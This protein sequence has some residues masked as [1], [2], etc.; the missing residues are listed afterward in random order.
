[1][2]TSIKTTL[3]AVALGMASVAN[4]SMI[5]QWSYLNEAGFMDPS[6]GTVNTT[7]FQSAGSTILSEDTY[8][9]LNWGT[10]VVPAEG[11]SSLEIDTPISGSITTVEVGDSLEDSDFED[12][13]DI[14]HNNYRISGASLETATILD[15]LQ[16]VATAWDAAAPIGLIGGLAPEL[17]IG[18]EFLET[19]NQ[20]QNGI[21]VDGSVAGTDPNL[22]DFGCDDFFIIYP[23]PGVTITVNDLGDADP[24]N[25]YV[26]FK[27]TFDLIDLGFPAALAASLDLITKYEVVTRLTGL[28]INTLFCGTQSIP[29]IGFRT[30][31]LAT[32]VLQA[33]FA[34]RAVPAPASLAFLGMGIVA[35]ALNARRKRVQK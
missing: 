29:C 33:S 11:N 21:C 7:G 13:T 25:D 8:T 20:P 18:F 14:T 9:G 4:A 28:S 23:I 10:P 22:P 19:S 30:E 15:G 27:N 2:K 6:P 3:A 1:M 12:G 32:N 34:I 26:E 16:L 24:T 17:E 35:L 5:T 31:E